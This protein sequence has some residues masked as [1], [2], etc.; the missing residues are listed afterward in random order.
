MVDFFNLEGFF[1]HFRPRDILQRIF[2]FI[3][4]KIIYARDFLKIWTRFQRVS[5][6]GLY[7]TTNRP[8]LKRGLLYPQG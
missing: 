5:S 7:G 3:H 6:Q 8:G 2:L 4:L 1:S